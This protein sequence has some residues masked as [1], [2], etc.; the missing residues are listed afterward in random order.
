MEKVGIYADVG[1]R[2]QAARIHR[3]LGISRVCL[4]PLIAD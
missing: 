4:A 1:C 3:W 2:L